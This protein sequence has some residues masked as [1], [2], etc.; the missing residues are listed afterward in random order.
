MTPFL[1]VGQLLTLYFFIIVYIFF[2]FCGFY[3]K[4]VYH[5]HFY[6]CNKELLAKLKEFRAKEKELQDYS[7][8]FSK[9]IKNI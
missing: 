7:L 5:I 2:P 8:V 6:R 3:E 1:E 4:L 9:D